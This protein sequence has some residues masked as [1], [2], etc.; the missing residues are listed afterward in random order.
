MTGLLAIFAGALGLVLALGTAV[1]VSLLTSEARGSIPVICR[2]LLARTAARLPAELEDRRGEWECELF[3]AKDRPLT[4]VVVALR[5]WREGRAIA[6][7]AE[8][9][10]AAPN[11]TAVQGTRPQAAGLSALLTMFMRP[12]ERL[13]RSIVGR[14][15]FRLG[16]IGVL[17]LTLLMVF[18]TALQVAALIAGVGESNLASWL[19]S[20]LAGV[21]VLAI[22]AYLRTRIKDVRRGSDQIR[23]RN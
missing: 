4:Q 21:G 6:S 2:R 18:L 19:G 12:L 13:R 10:V 16:L 22:G 3:E 5:I 9:L 20:A 23:R 11:S 8:A 1:G 7:E 15:T 17:G 14:P